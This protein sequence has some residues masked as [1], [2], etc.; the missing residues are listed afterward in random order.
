[1]TA[2]KL[3]LYNSDA[4]PYAARAVIALDE[5]KQQHEVIPID[6]KVPRPEWYLK[7]INPYGQVPALKVDDKDIILESLLVAEYVADL[8][9]EAG[10]LPTDPLQRAQTRYLI[11]HWGA[12]VQPVF[13]KASFTLDAAEAAKSR[14]ELIVELGKFNKLLLDAHRKEGDNFGTGPFYLGEK[15]TFADLA[16]APF[17]ARFHLLEAYNGNKG[18]TLEKNPELKRFLEWKEAIVSRASVQKATPSKETLTE[19]YRKWVK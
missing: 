12:R 5:T 15:F 8:H 10:L 9:P 16:I 11:H 18:V 2:P 7:D 14:E 6:L 17:L 1:M 3:V 13:H 19:N 4:C